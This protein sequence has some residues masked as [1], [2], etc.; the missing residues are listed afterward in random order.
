MSTPTIH[1]ENN[2]LQSNKPPE[3]VVQPKPPSQPMFSSEQHP[4]GS[5]G[6]S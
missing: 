2:L 5:P 6:L 4:P 1:F 3:P